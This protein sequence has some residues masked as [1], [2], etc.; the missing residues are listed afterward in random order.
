MT[1]GTIERDRLRYLKVYKRRARTVIT[2][3]VVGLILIILGICLRVTFIFLLALIP[4]FAGIGVMMARKDFADMY[5][6]KYKLNIIYGLLN[7]YYD[8]VSYIKHSF[9]PLKG[10]VDSGLFDNKIDRFNKEDVITGTYNGI[11]F[12]A[13]DATLEKKHT[14]INGK[15][16]IEEYITFFK[17]RWYEFDLN[18]SFNT[19]I[20]I[21]EIN[22]FDNFKVDNLKEVQVESYDF[23]SRFKAYTDNEQMFFYIFTPKVIESVLKLEEIHDG[24]FMFSLKNNIVNIGINDSKDYLELNLFNEVSEDELKPIEAQISMMAAIINEFNFDGYKYQ[25]ENYEDIKNIVEK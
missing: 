6:N 20:I 21:K 17:G 15:T 14:E 25:E 11:K 18:R 23:S 13:F 9:M 12:I 1:L 5:S 3:L 2:L 4:I 8:D 16:P 24:Q 19:T 22:K 7:K 10:V